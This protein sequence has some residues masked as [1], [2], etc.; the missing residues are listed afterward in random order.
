MVFT[1]SLSQ[2]STRPVTVRWGMANGTAI[3]GRD[4]VATAG[5]VTFGPG[6]TRRTITAVVIGDRTAEADETFRIGLAS[7]LNA[8]LSATANRGTGTI[9]NDDGPV[10]LAA[11]FAAIASTPSP[12]TSTKTRR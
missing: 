12:A 6:E 11:A 2:A 5:S 9:R 10:R 7:P 3:A 8:T 4:Y 1:V